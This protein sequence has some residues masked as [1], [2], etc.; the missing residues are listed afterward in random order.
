[1]EIDDS[2]LIVKD[3]LKNFILNEK[4][5]STTI[6]EEF[7]SYKYLIDFDYDKNCVIFNFYCRNFQE[8]YSYAVKDWLKI[9]YPGMFN[10][11]TYL[12]TTYSRFKIS[13]KC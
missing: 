7:G 10:I 9:K 11:N 6:L 12:I 5:N 1:M 4:F 2:N 3:S 13:I 8:M